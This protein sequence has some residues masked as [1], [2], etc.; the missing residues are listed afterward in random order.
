VL[1]SLG[2][3]PTEIMISGRTVAKNA[4]PSENFGRGRALALLGAAPT[5][6]MIL[7]HTVAKNVLPSRVLPNPQNMGFI[8]QPRVLRGIPLVLL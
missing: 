4:L 7:G 2:A 5:K 1:A 6:I 8:L 3:A